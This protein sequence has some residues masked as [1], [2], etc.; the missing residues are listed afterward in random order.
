MKKLP[1]ILLA[2][3]IISCSSKTEVKPEDAPR[4]AFDSIY[5]AFIEDRMDVY[6]AGFDIDTTQI[7]EID[8]TRTQ[9][10][11]GIFRQHKEQL[12]ALYGGINH[13]DI[14]SIHFNNDSSEAQLFYNLV[15]NDST[16]HKCLQVMVKRGNEWKFK[17]KDLE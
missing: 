6:L 16:S 2:A 1:Y 7:N 11:Y 8:S 14:S 15:Y 10:L 4:I 9:L 17:L 12:N 5:S 13:Y 3:I